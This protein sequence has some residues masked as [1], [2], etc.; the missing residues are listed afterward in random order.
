MKKTTARG[1]AACLLAMSIATV[2]AHAQAPSPSAPQKL[3]L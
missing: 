1:I 2:S 3:T